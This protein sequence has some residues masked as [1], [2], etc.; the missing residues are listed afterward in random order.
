MLLHQFQ[1]HQ[2]LLLHALPIF[3]IIVVYVNK[4]VMEQAY[5]V[6]VQEA[7]QA[8]D[9]NIVSLSFNQTNMKLISIFKRK[10]NIIRFI[11]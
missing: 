1:Q 4:S 2:I 9:V 10:K 5:N 3:V 11:M 8:L 7:G 6:I